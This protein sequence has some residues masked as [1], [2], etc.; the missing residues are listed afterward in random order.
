MLSA[1]IPSG[2]GYQVP[3]AARIRREAGVPTAAVGLITDP[4]QADAVVREGQ[5]DMVALAR[6]ELRDPYWPMHAARALGC[7]L[8]WP[9]QYLRAKD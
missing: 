6:A 1:R 3:F 4:A 5:A 9:P 7:D 2:P 8:H